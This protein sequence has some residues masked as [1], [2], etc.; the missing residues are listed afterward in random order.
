M[1]NFDK[2]IKEIGIVVG[3][4][5]NEAREAGKSFDGS[6][7]WD[8]RPEEYLLDVISCD[9]ED[10]NV[11]TGFSNGTRAEYK[12]DKAT[13]DK[14]HFGSWGKVRYN[15]RQYGSQL[16]IRPESFVP[17]EKNPLESK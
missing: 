5:V 15:A 17:I 13:Y 8:A 9:E 16:T 1:P 7:S 14:V 2:P 11:D 4:K 10:F 12:V 6:R 3:K